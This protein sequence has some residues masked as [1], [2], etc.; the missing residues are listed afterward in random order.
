MG[1]TGGDRDTGEDTENTGGDTGNTGGIDDGGDTGNTNNTGGITDSVQTTPGGGTESAS[2]DQIDEL[3]S[4]GLS[5]GNM[6][7]FSRFI[8]Y[9][10]VVLCACLA[11]LL[12]H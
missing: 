5:G 9:S 2:G 1:N 6:N 12:R 11:I 10:S 7:S 3:S 8:M 4:A